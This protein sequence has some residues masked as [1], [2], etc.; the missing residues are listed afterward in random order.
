[1]ICDCYKIIPL[2]ISVL[3]FFS[4]LVL[5]SSNLENWD[6]KKLGNTIWP[7]L[8]GMQTGGR[9]YGRGRGLC[10]AERYTPLPTFSL[11]LSFSFLSFFFFWWSV[12]LVFYAFGVSFNYNHWSPKAQK[13]QLGSIVIM[14]KFI[15]KAIC[16]CIRIQADWHLPFMEC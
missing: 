12:C 9:N 2:S 10:A 13:T 1:M 5:W 15:P 11:F 4:Y 7:F 16:L 3:F 8:W 6:H 14:L